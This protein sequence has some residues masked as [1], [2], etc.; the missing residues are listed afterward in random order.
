VRG[1]Q[2]HFVHSK[3]MVWVGLDRA[4]HLAERGVIDW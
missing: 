1:P 2:R 3:L 4:V